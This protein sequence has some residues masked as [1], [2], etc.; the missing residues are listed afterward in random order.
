MSQT[1]TRTYQRSQILSFFELNDA[2]QL[3]ASDYTDEEN[4][5][6]DQYVLWNNEPLPLSMFMRTE[7]G[8]FGGVY[9]QSAF[10]AYFIK[11]NKTGEWATVVYA[12]C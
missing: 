9:G 8:L 2:Q 11:I 3:Q 5:A 4:A 12:Y 1:L 10:S 7:S 6:N